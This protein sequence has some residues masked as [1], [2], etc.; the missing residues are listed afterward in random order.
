MNHREVRLHLVRH[1]RTAS[2]AA[3]TYTGMRDVDL[4]EEGLEGL[5]Q[6]MTTGDY[7]MVTKVFV[8]PLK[9][10]QQTA[11]KLFPN[12]EKVVVEGLIEYNFGEY[13]GHTSKE[14]AKRQDYLDWT[15]GL[16]EAAPPKGETNQAFNDRIRQTVEDLIKQIAAETAQTTDTAN[17]A[18]VSHG[19][20]IMTIMSMFAEPK[21][22]TT[23]W[24]MVN[25]TGYTVTAV[26]EDELRFTDIAFYPETEEN[27]GKTPNPLELK[28]FLP[29]PF[30]T[31]KKE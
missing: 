19:G 30:P 23:D 13:E 12:V 4:S 3:G 7:G 16:P 29:T 28:N 24:F 22:T 21:A 14:L 27:R 18:I 2:N 15:A 26:L 25:G 31:L 17:V 9:R 5:E 6:L 8:S 11:E 10:C 1:G 20:V